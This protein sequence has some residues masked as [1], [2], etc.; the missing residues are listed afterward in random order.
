MRASNWRQITAV[1]WLIDRPDVHDVV[2]AAIFICLFWGRKIVLCPV[3]LI[4]L[5]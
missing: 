3:A 2:S 1:T 5:N 4:F